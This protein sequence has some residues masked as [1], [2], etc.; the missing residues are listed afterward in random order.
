[1]EL[2]LVFRGAESPPT[3][4]GYVSSLGAA[5]GLGSWTIP[6]VESQ[7]PIIAHPRLNTYHS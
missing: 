6:A 2:D 4:A 7:R 5:Q 1:M 3:A